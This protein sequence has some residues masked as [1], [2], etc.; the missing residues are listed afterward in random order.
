MKLWSRYFCHP[1]SYTHY[2]LSFLPLFQLA[3][4]AQVELTLMLCTD[5]WSAWNCNIQPHIFR[6]SVDPGVNLYTGREYHTL[7]SWADKSRD[8][9]LTLPESQP[10]Q[11]PQ[12]LVSAVLLLNFENISLT[13]LQLSSFFYTFLNGQSIIADIREV[14]HTSLTNYL[15]AKH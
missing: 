6:R 7:C 10:N 9:F 13:Q 1:E 12:L 4:L 5:I 3:W 14:N 11:I 2:N 8:Y 15:D